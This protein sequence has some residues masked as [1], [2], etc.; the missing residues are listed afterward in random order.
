MGPAPMI[1]LVVL[2][3]RL[4]ITAHGLEFGHKKRARYRASPEPRAR[5]LPRARVGLRPDFWAAKPRKVPINR[6]FWTSGMT[7]EGGGMARPNPARPGR[8]GPSSHP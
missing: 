6:Q 7:G 1:R 4:G 2:F 8:H 3:V 5:G